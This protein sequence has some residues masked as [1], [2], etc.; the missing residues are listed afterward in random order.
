MQT[1][2]W[3]TMYLTMWQNNL[4]R[5]DPHDP[6]DEAVLTNLTHYKQSS[7]TVPEVYAKGRRESLT[8]HSRHSERCYSHTM[9]AVTNQLVILSNCDGISVFFPYLCF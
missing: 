6:S 8:K 9:L 2:V 7:T 4:N 1:C 5:D 3:Y